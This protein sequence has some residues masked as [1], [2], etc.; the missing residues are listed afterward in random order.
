M[1]FFLPYAQL[2][3]WPKTYKD[4]YTNSS[5]SFSVIL[6]P[7]WYAVPQIPVPTKASNSDLC[8]L[9]LATLLCLF[10]LYFLML[11]IDHKMPSGRKPKELWHLLQVFPFSQ[12]S[13]SSGDSSAISEDS[14]LIH[15]TQFYWCFQ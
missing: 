1:E 2:S 4:L 14:C 6:P 10:G 12:E 11:C 3:I 13:W 9:Y 8:L 7:L 15:L 5:I